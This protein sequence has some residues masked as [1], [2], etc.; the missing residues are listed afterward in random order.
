MVAMHN[1]L[2]KENFE[3]KFAFRKKGSNFHSI[4]HWANELFKTKLSFQ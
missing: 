2:R 3:M 1:D 4:N